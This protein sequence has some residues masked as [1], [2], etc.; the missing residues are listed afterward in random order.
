MI[1]NADVNTTHSDRRLDGHLP[2][3]NERVQI[4]RLDLRVREATGTTLRPEESI[5]S[6]NAFLPKPESSACG[7]R[8][9]GC[10]RPS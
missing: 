1:I 7:I 3:R 10:C 9:S 4:V 2:A 5:R 8:H 6:Q